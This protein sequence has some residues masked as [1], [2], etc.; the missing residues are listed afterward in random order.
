MKTGSFQEVEDALQGV[1]G[2]SAAGACL[3]LP[4]GTLPLLERALQVPAAALGAT[5]LMLPALYIGSALCGVQ[6]GLRQVVA[7]TALALR[8]SGVFL[9]GLAPALAFLL[10]TIQGPA[11]AG[12]LFNGALLLAAVLGLRRLHAVLLGERAESGL[13]LF[14]AWCAVLVGLGGTMLAHVVG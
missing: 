8:A 3:G 1:A 11:A 14:G 2:W 10:V 7:S 9:L 13:L 5:V 4:L 12:I 6:S